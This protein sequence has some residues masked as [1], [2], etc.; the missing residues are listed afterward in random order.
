[1]AGRNI[2]VFAVVAAPILTQHADDA[3][4]EL[5]ERWPVLRRLTNSAPP[6]RG[7][8]VLNWILL[9][10]VAAAVLV[11]VALPLNPATTTEAIAQYAPVG[12]A[13]YLKVTPTPGLLFNSYN[14]GGYLAW[15]LYPNRLIYVDGRTDLYD[16]IFLNEYLNA[17]QAGPGWQQ[18]FVKYGIATVV[19][20]TN[21]PIALELRQTPGWAVRYS[22]PV[23]VILVKSQ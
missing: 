21:A 2:A 17:Y 18:T 4:R 22:D 23:S 20:E 14:F 16:D 11:K 10:L 15:A 6:S 3:I 7:S 9:A 12:A 5:Q 8:Q 1:L 19:V 13:N